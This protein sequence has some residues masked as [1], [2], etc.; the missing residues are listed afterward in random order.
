[1]VPFPSASTSFIMS[2]SSASVGFWPKE[3]IT[4]PNSRVVIVPSPSV[5]IFRHSSWVGSGN[6]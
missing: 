5:L 2:C 3:R 4:V 1:M 6:W